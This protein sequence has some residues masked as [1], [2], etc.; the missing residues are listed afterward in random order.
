MTTSSSRRAASPCYPPGWRSRGEANCR[1]D[2]LQADAAASMGPRGC[3]ASGSQ[4]A[5]PRRRAL[6]SRCAPPRLAG[7]APA[8]WRAAAAARRGRCARAR[9]CRT[10]AVGRTARGPPPACDKRAS[11]LGAQHEDTCKA[12][13]WLSGVQRSR[14]EVEGAAAALAP[15]VRTL[16]SL[17][18]PRSEGKTSL[19]VDA[20]TAAAIAGARHKP[21]FRMSA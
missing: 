18:S 20:A 1:P 15:F 4:G 2:T 13:L 6:S 12:L 3:S 16:R 19:A 17:V 9:A 5:A 21:E 11:T 10:A 7:R 14:A 8:R